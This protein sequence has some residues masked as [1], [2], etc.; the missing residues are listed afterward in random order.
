M[1]VIRLKYICAS[2]TGFL[3][4]LRRIRQMAN[5]ILKATQNE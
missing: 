1:Q 4:N 2:L 5:Y 3:K